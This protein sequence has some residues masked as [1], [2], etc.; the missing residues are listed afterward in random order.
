MLFDIIEILI[1]SE[2]AL[3]W[4]KSISLF[5]WE[6]DYKEGWVPKNWCFQIVVL[7]KILESPLDCREIKLVNPKGS[8]LW[9]F[10]G[11]TDAEAEAPVLWPPDAKSQVNGKDPDA[12]KD[13]RQ[14]DKGM[15]EDEMVGWHHWLNG[16][17]SEQIQIVKDREARHVVV[18]GLQRVGY[19]LKTDQ[20][21]TDPNIMNHFRDKDKVCQVLKIIDKNEYLITYECVDAKMFKRD[22]S[23]FCSVYCYVKTSPGVGLDWAGWKCA[24]T[25]GKNSRGRCERSR[26]MGSKIEHGLQRI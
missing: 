4:I 22:I 24:G 2:W 15:T 21:H 8:Q 25:E 1:V 13:L 7:E 6:L 23:Y 17:E 18:M 3:L 5:S 11:R 16:H 20:R 10:T 19:D 12:G 9:I 26:Q 14:E